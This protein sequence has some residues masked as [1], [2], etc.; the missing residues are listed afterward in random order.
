MVTFSQHL[1]ISLMVFLGFGRLVSFSMPFLGS[2]A[3]PGPSIVT[4]PLSSPRPSFAL[5]CWNVFSR[6]VMIYVITNFIFLLLSGFIPQLTKTFAEAT[7]ASTTNELSSTSTV[8]GASTATAG[9]HP[10][11]MLSQN[12]F[13]ISSGPSDST[14]NQNYILISPIG[15]A[16]ATAPLVSSPTTAVVLPNTSAAAAVARNLLLN[17]PSVV[18]KTTNLTVSALEVKA[19]R[20]SPPLP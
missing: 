3:A 14:N 7:S 6:R 18:A 12:S 13:I 5:L 8:S 1:L 4:Y 20:V 9:V 16:A 11:G 10:T 15:T 2:V 19:V 17:D